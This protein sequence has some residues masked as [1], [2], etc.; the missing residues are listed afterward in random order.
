MGW[1]TPAEQAALR[2]LLLAGGPSAHQIGEAATF[3]ARLGSTPISGVVDVPCVVVAPDPVGDNPLQV[4]VLLTVRAAA[5]P[6]PR[7][8]VPPTALVDVT[9]P[10]GSAV[11]YTVL[12][13]WQPGDALGLLWRLE[14]RR[15]TGVVR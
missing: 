7:P 5:L 15:A 6:D 9:L 1:F 2:D 4:E 11:T 3:T 13:G 8:A 10:D 12:R 14:L